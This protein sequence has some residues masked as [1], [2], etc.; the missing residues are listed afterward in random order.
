MASKYM[1]K[2]SN[3]LVIKEMQMKTTL[4]FHLTLV[5][6]TIFKIITTTNLVR[7]QQNRIPYTLLVR[8]QPLWKAVWRV[9]KKLKIELPYDPVI[10]LLVW[11]EGKWMQLEDIM[12]SEV[13]QAQKDKCV[14]FSSY[15][16]NRSKKAN[17]Y[18]KQT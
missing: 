3:S 8:M 9:L 18:K 16:E 13:S 11:F 1:K 17:I 4:R 6:M 14:C 7:M 12:L 10:P 5:R 2:C 15:M